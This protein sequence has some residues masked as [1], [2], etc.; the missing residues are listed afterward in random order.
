VFKNYFQAYQKHL[1]T[2][3]DLTDDAINFA[4]AYLKE[5]VVGKTS[6]SDCFH[7]TIAIINEVGILVS[8][9]FKRV[10]VQN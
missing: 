8:W 7:I 3:V 4:D 6:R 10:K 9:N 2:K 5:N 1:K